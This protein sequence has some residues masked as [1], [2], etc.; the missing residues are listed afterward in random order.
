[1]LDEDVRGGS[2]SGP[3]TA[4]SVSKHADLDTFVDRVIIPALV[5]RFLSEHAAAYDAA[6][7]VG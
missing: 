3:I 1:M 5:E 6:R 7:V 2:V 4:T